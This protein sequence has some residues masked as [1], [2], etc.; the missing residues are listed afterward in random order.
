MASYKDNVNFN[1][2]NELPSLEKLLGTRRVGSHILLGG[3][4]VLMLKSG[5]LLSKELAE[6]NGEEK[7]VI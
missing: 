6:K 5:D 3:S 1:D 7:P 4:S 2:Y